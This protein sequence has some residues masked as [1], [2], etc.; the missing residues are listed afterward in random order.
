MIHYFYG[1]LQVGIG[2]TLCSFEHVSCLMNKADQ[3]CRPK[4]RD[5]WSTLIIPHFCRFDHHFAVITPYLPAPP[6]SWL[7]PGAVRHS[8]RPPP[9]TTPLTVHSIDNNKGKGYLFSVM[10]TR[11]EHSRPRPRPNTIKA[12]AEAKATV[13]RPRPRPRPSRLGMKLLLYRH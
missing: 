4:S 9:L 3:F 7:P 1:T 10:L 11:P 2:Q 13:P 8:A 12:K 6:E 5:A